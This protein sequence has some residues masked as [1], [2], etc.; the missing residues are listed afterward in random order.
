M[1]RAMLKMILVFAEAERELIQSRMAAGKQK[2]A[3]EGGYN[4][5]PVRYGYRPGAE[6]E[7]DFEIV[8]SEASIVEAIFKRYARGDIGITR[9]KKQTK[10]PLSEPAIHELLSSV[11][12]IG[13]IQ[14]NG[15]VAFNNHAPIVSDRIYN[16]VQEVKRQRSKQAAIG[17]YKVV[18]G[19]AEIRDFH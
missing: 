7:R 4:G 18:E 19:K 14:Y 10:C 16:R 1:G 9:L 6:D 11:F 12:Y 8:K 17:L 15:V 13:R 3:S 2:R 5:G